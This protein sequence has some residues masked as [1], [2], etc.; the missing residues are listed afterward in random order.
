MEIFLS[1]YF[2]KELSISNYI[3]VFFSYFSYFSSNIF[4]SS[5]LTLAPCSFTCSIISFFISSKLLTFTLSCIN[6]LICSLSSLAASSSLSILI[7]L[8]LISFIILK[9]PILLSLSLAST[10]LSSIFFHRLNNPIFLDLSS[11]ANLSVNTLPIGEYSNFTFS[12]ASG[13]D[14]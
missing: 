6:S 10:R 12:T 13:L 2:S 7:P 8:S 11:L 9:I 1:L 3:Y 4:H 14:P 5:K